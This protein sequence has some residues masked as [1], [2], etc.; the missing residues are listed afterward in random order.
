MQ[1]AAALPP[2]APAW[3]WVQGL[4]I[5]SLGTLVLGLVLRPAASLFALWEIVIPLVPA[6]LLI[7]P[8]LWRNVCPFAT[9]NMVGNGRRARRPLPHRATKAFAWSG[10]TLLFLLVPARRFLFNESGLALAAVIVA[11]AVAALVLGTVYDHKAGFCNAFCP[12]LPVEKL[13]G[14]AALVEVS[15]PR[16][17]PCVGCTVKGC[18]DRMPGRALLPLAQRTPRAWLRQP[19]GVFAMAFPG[20]I[21][22]YFTVANGPLGDAGLI[23]GRVF[24]AAAISWALLA[25]ICVGLK[26]R[27]RQAMP[28]LAAL[29]IGLYYAF[30]TP[31]LS[32]ALHLGTPGLW[33]LRLLF[34]GLIIFWLIRALQRVPKRRSLALQP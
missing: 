22:G 25:G 27:A 3:R 24:L 13:Y 12:L 11:V 23:Y 33:G 14:Q 5:L 29:A 34:G 6:L 18:L 7:S 26:I 28:V 31:G 16:C 2:P 17:T 8:A 10:L 1:P 15:N 4:S 30:A 32:D 19:Y 21:V 9:L 20:F